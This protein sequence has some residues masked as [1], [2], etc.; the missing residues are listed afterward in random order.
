VKYSSIFP[1]TFPVTVMVVVTKTVE[2][3]GGPFRVM[4]L[5]RGV[6]M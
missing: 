5:L 2:L 3:G 4:Q 1:V 6:G